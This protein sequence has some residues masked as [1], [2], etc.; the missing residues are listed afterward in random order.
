M[1]PIGESRGEELRFRR[2]EKSRQSFSRLG[3]FVW[4]G[5]ARLLE[6]Q[7][8]HLD[9]EARQFGVDLFGRTDQLTRLRQERAKR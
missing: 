2:L 3:F 5:C 9:R 1:D 6:Q 8:R 4:F 7:A